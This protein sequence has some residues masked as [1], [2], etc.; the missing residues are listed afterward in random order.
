MD[1]T[2]SHWG[3]RLVLT[4]G[5]VALA[6]AAGALALSG[7]RAPLRAAA[8]QAQHGGGPAAGAPLVCTTGYTYS[9]GTGSFVPG[10]TD[11]GNH[12]DDCVSHITLPFPVSLYGQSYS[13]GYVSSNGNLQ[14]SGNNTI[15]TS[16]CLPVPNFNATFFLYQY[17]LRTDCTGCGVY[18]TVTG[19]APNRLLYI[20]WRAGFF[21][22]NRTSADFELRLNEDGSD[23]AYIYGHVD[24]DGTGAMI[25]VEQSASGGYTQYACNDPA[26]VSDG[27][28]L[29][30]ACGP[31]PATPTPTPNPQPPT[32]TSTPP[33]T[34]NTPTATLPMPPQPTP[35]A[36]CT[37]GYTYTISSGT[38]VSGTDD[39]GNHCYACVT[40]ITLPFPVSLYGRD[41][42]TANVDSRGFLQ[43]A[44]SGYNSILPYTCLPA[45]GLMY[46][47]LP[48]STD[49]D[50]DD[51]QP[52]CKGCG[53]L[54]ASSGSAPNR[55]FNIEWRAAYLHAPG[56]ADFE[57]RFYENSTRF[58]FI[59]DQVDDGGLS[60]TVGVQ[61]TYGGS[62]TQYQCNTGGIS[63]GLRIT[64]DLSGC[65]GSARN[66]P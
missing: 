39:I 61:Q 6:S 34:T 57:L 51:T 25:G 59:Y 12:C 41:F 63:P 3:A 2:L 56:I 54:T 50:T 44:T 21:P 10:A 47:L 16:A 18:T 24:G 53:V 30:W 35:T 27:L 5:L 20:E 49:L 38:L 28:Q 14:L 36:P 48:L 64:W 26:S 45:A 29:T 11:T 52:D 15:F 22:P 32:P 55:V 62:Y 7:G 58:D 46:A 33:P 13:D 23:F 9:I 17:D 60:A 40:T 37:A 31:P 42:T 65:S 19:T 43:F 66:W 1:R 8:P 4:L